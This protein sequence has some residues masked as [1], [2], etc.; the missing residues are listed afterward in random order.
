MVAYLKDLL[1]MNIIFYFNQMEYIHPTAVHVSWKKWLL[2]FFFAYPVWQGKCILGKWILSAW[3]IPSKTIICF[4]LISYTS[5][6]FS[7]KFILFKY[8]YKNTYNCYLFSVLLKVQYYYL[9]ILKDNESRT[10][11]LFKLCTQLNTC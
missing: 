3:C 11:L 1:I 2:L 8:N 6:N 9:T 7:N 5:W 4:H 10:I